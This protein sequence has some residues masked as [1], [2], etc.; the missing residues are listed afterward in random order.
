MTDRVYQYK[1]STYNYIQSFDYEGTSDPVTVSGT[2]LQI[3][4]NDWQNI[5]LVNQALIHT[6]LTT[7]GFEL[8]T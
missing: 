8:V 3:I 5:S 4:V 7:A 6:N 2:P 1:L